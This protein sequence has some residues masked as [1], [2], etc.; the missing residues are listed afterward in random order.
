MHSYLG[1]VPPSYHRYIRQLSICTKS[2]TTSPGPVDHT[3]VSEQCRQLLSQCTQVERLTLNLAAALDKAV[4]PCFDGLH[5]LQV[6]TINH[7]GDEQ[8]CPL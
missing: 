3:L 1:N 6:L 4:I 2:A 8:T 7:S 5:A